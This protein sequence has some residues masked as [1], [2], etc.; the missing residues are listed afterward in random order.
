MATVV[1]PILCWNQWT[2]CWPYV[3]LLVQLT[4]CME[5]KSVDLDNRKTNLAEV[6][7][8][9]DGNVSQIFTE[10]YELTTNLF[11]AQLLAGVDFLGDTFEANVSWV[12]HERFLKSLH[13]R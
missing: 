7:E 5:C 3:R 13:H 11:I 1:C 9:S 12:V 10:H 4:P 2:P 6:E 8:Q